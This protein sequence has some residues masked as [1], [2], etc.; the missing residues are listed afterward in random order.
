MVAAFPGDYF[1][2][3]FQ[4]LIIPVDV[5]VYASSLHPKAVFPWCVLFCRRFCASCFL[6]G[7]MD[8]ITLKIV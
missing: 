1:I 6:T 8:T 7:K 2:R 4:I 5:V 3:F